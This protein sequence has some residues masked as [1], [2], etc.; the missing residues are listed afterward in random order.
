MI[1]SPDT[2]GAIIVAK[3]E[4][5]SEWQKIFIKIAPVPMGGFFIKW[6][7]KDGELSLCP[8][9]SPIFEP[10]LSFNRGQWLYQDQPIRPLLSIGAFERGNFLWERGKI[11][12]T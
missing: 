10:A 12:E 7:E 3:G 8:V 5:P 6:E 4:N 1:F 9:I 11:N 2:S